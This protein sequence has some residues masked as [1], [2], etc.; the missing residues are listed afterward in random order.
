MSA[1]P[2]SMRPRKMLPLAEECLRASEDAIAMSSDPRSVDQAQLYA[3]QS[4]AA[5]LILIARSEA[6][7]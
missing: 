1:E 5:S 6:E 3:I 2:S 7:R 4:I